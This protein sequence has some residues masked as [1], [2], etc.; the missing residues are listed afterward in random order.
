MNPVLYP[1]ELKILARRERSLR[2][3]KAE[4]GSIQMFLVGIL[5]GLWLEPLTPDAFPNRPLSIAQGRQSGSSPC[6]IHQ[7]EN[8]TSFVS[9]SA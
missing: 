2:T 5:W 6:E 7:S 9:H 4:D 3:L 8:L 1:D